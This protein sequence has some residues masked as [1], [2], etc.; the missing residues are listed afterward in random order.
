M[1]MERCTQKVIGTHQEAYAIEKK[2]DMLEVGMENVP[3]KRR[4]WAGYGGLPANTMVWERDWP[5]LAALEVYNQTISKDPKWR[6]AFDESVGVYDDMVFE[7]LLPI[8]MRD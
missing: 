3:G 1:I 7:I 5:S 4:N 6:D 2:F 8:D